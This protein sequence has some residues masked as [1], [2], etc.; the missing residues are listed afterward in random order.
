LLLKLMISGLQSN[1]P[2]NMLFNSHNMLIL[3]P[4]LILALFPIAG[5]SYQLQV[6]FQLWFLH[7]HHY[8]H[9]KHLSYYSTTAQQYSLLILQILHNTSTY[10][11]SSTLLTNQT[12]TIY[13]SH[14]PYKELD[15]LMT[16]L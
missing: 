15:N 16:L 9:L 7:F 1:H 11:K 5:L 13:L 6:P 10:V 2:K 14:F 12:L 4:Q 8:E 3:L